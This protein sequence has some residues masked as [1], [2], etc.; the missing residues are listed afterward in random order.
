MDVS[1][2]GLN[3]I[4]FILLVIVT[5]YA[6][7][8]Y[9]LGFFASFVD[10]ISFV[11]SFVFGLAF[12]SR[13]SEVLVQVF[14]IPQGF[15]NALGFLIAAIMFEIIFSVVLKKIFFS[16]PAFMKSN[17]NLSK[18]LP[19]EKLLGVFPGVLS[20][21]VLSAFILSLI[22]AL[23]FS[24][25]L[26]NSVTDSRFGNVLVS[27]TQ[28]FAHGLNEVFGGAVNDTLSFLT[29]E[30]QSDQSVGLNF[31]AENISVDYAA[32]QEMFAKVNMER[33]SQGLSILSFSEQLAKVGRAHCSDMFRRGYFSHYT[34]EGLS[35]FDRMV[36]ADVNFK[37]AG[38]NLAL[39]PNV[40]LAMQGLMNSEGHKAN[41]LSKDFGKVG[42]GA[43]DGGVYG[44][45][46][47]QEFTD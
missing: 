39:A 47:C 26:K 23:P 22:I 46:Y 3:W 37:F 19:F 14:S 44:Q 7:E 4:D 35:P 9:F 10:F 18:L 40:E 20:G 43:I 27:N 21:L 36:A 38:E 15:A 25:F 32:E 11:L 8:G 1:Y 5:I 16:F 33:S 24:V 29:V 28:V 42:I 41:I 2:F 34:P 45:M 30:P 17:P 31:K 12:Y 6:I 13:L